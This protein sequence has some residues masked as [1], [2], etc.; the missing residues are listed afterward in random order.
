MTDVRLFHT[1]DGGEIEYVNGR[2]T[3]AAGFESAVYLSLFGG[4]ERDGGSQITESLQWWG[5]L[6]EEDPA[7]KYRSE[8]QHL[9][10]SIPAIPANIPRI[11]DAVARDLEWMKG[12]L[13][14]EL[15]IFVTLPALN[16][17]TIEIEAVI[18]DQAFRA[19]FLEIWSA[20][21]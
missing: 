1:S 14:A 2:V 21:T 16:R 17:I 13:G 4:N 5:N 20:T 12:E 19:V 7:R 11:A 10:R 3:L 8:T 15:E 9:L 6:L 18:Q